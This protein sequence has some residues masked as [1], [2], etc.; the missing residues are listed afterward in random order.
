METPA[1]PD[2]PPE[3]ALGDA[4]LD[5]VEA[6]ILGCLIEK[7]LTTPE[8]YPLTL[9]GLTAACNQ[10]SNRLPVME[11]AETDVVRGLDRLQTKGLSVTTHQA[12]A[13]VAKYRHVFGNQF[14]LRQ[15]ETAVMAELL[16][17][18]PQTEGELK[19]RAGRMHP[20]VNLAEVAEALTRLAERTPPLTV[21]LPRRPGHKEPRW[22]HLLAGPPDP[23]DLA[24]AAPRPEAAVVRVRAEAERVAALEARVAALE[25]AFEGFRKQFE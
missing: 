12:G 9:K 21:L 14:P 4:P 7:Q 13:R 16:L 22:A 25:A 10:Q 17:R 5:P 1:Q 3:S 19:N 11:L 23:A 6:R 15:P 18:G 20:F 8:V 24:A 2:T